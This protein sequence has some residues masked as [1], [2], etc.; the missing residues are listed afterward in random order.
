QGLRTNLQSI[1]GRLIL[2]ALQQGAGNRNKAAELLGISPR[3][4]RYKIARLRDA[5]IEVPG[6]YASNRTAST[7]QA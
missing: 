6:R 1:E 7:A 5:G 4:L 3:T 2:D